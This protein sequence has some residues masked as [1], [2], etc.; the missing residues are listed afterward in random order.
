MKCP[1]DNETLLMTERSGVEIDYCPK[2]R[3]VWLD[4]GELE[5]IIERVATVAPGFAPSSGHDQ[6]GL[7][8]HSSGHGHDNH[9]SH[10]RDPH[11]GEH[12][13]NAYRGRREGLL[14]NLF[15]F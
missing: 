1:I 9:D 11:H 12:A 3:G 5:K 6:D 13:S 14:S 8:R 2:C 15:D 4:R 7:R 10:G